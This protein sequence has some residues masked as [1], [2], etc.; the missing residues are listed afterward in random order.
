MT[1]TI[2]HM[3]TNAVTGK[4]HVIQLRLRNG[5]TAA[6]AKAFLAGRIEEGKH[7]NPETCAI[8]RNVVE[9]VDIY[10]LC[11]VPDKWSCGGKELFVRNP[12][13]GQWV[14]DGDLP[15]KIC[16]AVYD[17]IEREADTYTPTSSSGKTM[18]GRERCAS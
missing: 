1:N 12:P 14:W 13:D 15:E 11:D 18:I 5:I 17:R 8:I 4:S 9:A 6:K 2:P 7:I 3:T 10:G 16:K